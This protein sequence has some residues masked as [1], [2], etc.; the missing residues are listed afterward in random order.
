ML[1]YGKLTTQNNGEV[2]NRQMHHSDTHEK[3]G[4]Q[5]NGPYM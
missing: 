2:G 5:V 3:R 4:T 1:I